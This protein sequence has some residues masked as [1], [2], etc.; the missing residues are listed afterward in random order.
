V[1][2]D[3]LGFIFWITGKTLWALASKTGLGLKPLSDGLYQLLGFVVIL[4]VIFIIVF[5]VI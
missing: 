4:F 2:H 1:G 3:E 5:K